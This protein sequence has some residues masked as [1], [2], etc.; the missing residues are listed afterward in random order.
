MEYLE[1]ETYLKPCETLTRH[2]ENPA[3][4]HYSAI[5]RHIQNL[6]QC[7]HTQNPG[8]LGILEYSKPFHN[9]IPTHIQN[10]AILRKFMNIQIYLKPDTYSEL[11]QGFKIKFFAKIVENHNY[12]SK[13]LHLKSLTRF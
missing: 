4:G 9:C 1:P 7:L 8:T 12:F 3:I 10:P 6:V 5:F 11:S 2:I 13:V